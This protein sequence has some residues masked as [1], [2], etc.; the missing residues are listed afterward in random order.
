[1]NWLDLLILDF[2]TDNLDQDS[3]QSNSGDIN[4]GPVDHHHLAHNQHGSNHTSQW[5]ILGLGVLYHN[6]PTLTP[7][8]VPLL[9]ITEVVAHLPDKK[10]LDAGPLSLTTDHKCTRLLAGSLMV[11]HG[12]N[13]TAIIIQLRAPLYQ[14]QT[15]L[16]LALFSRAHLPQTKNNREFVP[17][18]QNINCKNVKS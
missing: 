13:R 3:P 17:T 12:L 5:W 7:G 9:S 1:M 10:D 2:Q 11:V 14:K 8:L 16:T 6:I 18:M 15:S 4:H